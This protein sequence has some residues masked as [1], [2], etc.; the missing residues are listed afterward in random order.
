MDYF[1]HDTDACSDEKVDA[2]R[3]IHG[4][5]GYAF[6]FILL[7]RIYRTA[8]FEL[9]VSD[10]E[11]KQILARK[12]DVTPQKFEEMLQTALKRRCFDPVAYAERGVLTS[13]GVKK[14]TESVM[15]KRQK[16]ATT[17]QNRVSDAE[18]EQKPDKGKESTE[19]ESKV[20]TTDQA[21]IQQHQSASASVKGNP[22]LTVP[23]PLPR[24]AI[25]LDLVVAGPYI[26]KQRTDMLNAPIS[27]DQACM[28]LKIPHAYYDRLV[29]AFFDQQIGHAERKEP[30]EY[31]RVKKHFDNWI[32]KQVNLGSQSD[33]HPNFVPV[34]VTPNGQPVPATTFRPVAATSAR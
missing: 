24:E 20:T 26:E 25:V 15:S 5:D 17:Y 28:K 3:M 21:Q 14:R 8:D 16:M 18:T 9:D 11:T 2:L 1:P 7:E 27:R 33:H 34:S 10:A 4:N 32:R 30:I 12:V 31:Y 22:A 19:K 6:Y 29:N 13:P 23:D